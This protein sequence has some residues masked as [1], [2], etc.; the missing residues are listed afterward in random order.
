MIAF[1]LVNSN[2]LILALLDV[3]SHAKEVV[4]IVA[5]ANVHLDVLY[6]AAINV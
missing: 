5:E 2:V 6:H 3:M 4:I 1:L